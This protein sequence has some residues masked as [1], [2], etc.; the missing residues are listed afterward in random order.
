MKVKK[1]TYM[2][3]LTAVALI[4]FVLESFI[5]AP[6]PVPGIK[7]GLANIVT[8]YAL[9][10]LRPG[11]ALTI[12]LTRI[13]LGSIFT[14]QLM[15]LL[16]SL[17]GGLLCF[18]LTLAARCVLTEQQIWVSSILGSMAHNVG[19]ILV[20][21][22]L[23]ATPGVAVYLSLLL[24]SAIITGSFTGFAAQQLYHH[25]QRLQ[26]LP[27]S[28][29]KPAVESGFSSPERKLDNVRKNAD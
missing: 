24:I 28:C 1:L 17:G 6:V 3:L 27:V 22:V 16:Y 12:L 11:E 4:I 13:I 19:Q 5:P 15:S 29:V 23:T 21:V 2:A 26:I 25:M 20:A 7:L 9:W 18:V 14:G 10:T 8:L